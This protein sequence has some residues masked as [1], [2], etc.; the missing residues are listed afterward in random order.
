MT[1][2]F[3]IEKIPETADYY[4]P[5]T[6]FRNN[7]HDAEG[8]IDRIQVVD[9]RFNESLSNPF[10]SRQ[11]D[12]SIFEIEDMIES[13]PVAPV[14]C[15]TSIFKSF[16]QGRNEEKWRGYIQEL[17]DKIEYFETT[18]FQQLRIYTG[19]SMW[20]DLDKAG[21]LKNKNVDFIKMKD[22]ST[23]WNIANTWRV[24]A[25]TDYSYDYVYFDDVHVFSPQ[26]NSDVTFET[27][28]EVF[29]DTDA[30]IASALVEPPTQYHT[31]LTVLPSDFISD[32]K[33]HFHQPIVQIVPID[34]FLKTMIFNWFR[35]PQQFPFT[36]MPSILLS[37]LNQHPL[38]QVYDPELNGW[39]YLQ[40]VVQTYQDVDAS[41]K[42]MFYLSRLVKLKLW[43]CHGD[44]SW[45]CE[46]YK[47][48]GDSFF[49][50]R[51]IEDVNCDL[52][53]GGNDSDW[54]EMENCV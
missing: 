26:R 11:F 34:A 25:L 23:G 43:I 2:P 42:V 54:T 37:C 22:S 36:D 45:Y 8:L 6:F 38:T 53:F 52:K 51:L 39:A 17:Q 44:L 24:M 33:H 13:E 18:P 29:S 10:S 4:L 27:I 7:L 32:I 35:G 48:S 30:S 12:A 3:F 28:Q 41:E 47:K 46:G 9:P 5:P 40:P 50:K 19:N 21:V 15:S 16:H 1:T 49:W 20:S 31:F 14:L